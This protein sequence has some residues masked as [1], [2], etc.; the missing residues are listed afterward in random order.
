MEPRWPCCPTTSGFWGGF[1]SILAPIS[2]DYWDNGRS[3]KTHNPPSLLEVFLVFGARLGGL[4]S[5]LGE[6]LGVVLRDLGPRWRTK[7]PGRRHIGAYARILEDLRGPGREVPP[8]TGCSQGNV[9]R[10]V[11]RGNLRCDGQ[12]ER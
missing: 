1:G 5:S 7:A 4:G 2:N 3:V 11:T 10:G 6:C 12:K 9:P 8:E